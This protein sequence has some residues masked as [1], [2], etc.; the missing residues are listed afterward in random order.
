MAKQEDNE[1]PEE[2]YRKLITLEKNC[3]FKDVKQEDLLI[4]K[5]ITSI[6]DKKLRVKLIREKILD[7]KT[8]VELVTQNSYDRRHKQSTISPVLAK[9]KEI[10]EELFQKNSSNTIS[11]TTKPTEEKYLWTLRTTELD[12]ST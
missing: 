11:R 6:T 4:S 7:M 12:R 2:H 1:T 5:I 3:D 8:T 10:K 9:D